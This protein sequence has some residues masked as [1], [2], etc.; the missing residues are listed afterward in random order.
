MNAHPVKQRQV[1]I[2]Q[3]PAGFELDV[4]PAFQSAGR[5]ARDKDGKVVMV[6]RTRVAHAASIE[7]YGMI[8]QGPV[9]LGRSL[10]L[11]KELRE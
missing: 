9:A 4:P 6:V 2:R 1:Q 3:W 7:V 10:E 11:F 5:A 8:E